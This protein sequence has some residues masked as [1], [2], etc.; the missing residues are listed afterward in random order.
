MLMPTHH[1]LIGIVGP[2]GAGKTTLAEGLGRAFP[3]TVYQEKP[4]ENPYFQEFYDDLHHQVKGSTAV[5]NSELFFLEAA[6]AQ[7]KAARE[8]LSSGIVIWD[9]PI[10]GHLM[11]A[12]LL[13]QQELLSEAQYQIYKKRYDECLRQILLPDLFLVA[14]VGS[15]QK[16]DVEILVE[17]IAQRGRP[18]ELETPLAYW[19]K[20]VA[21]WQAQT[22]HT[23]AV[24]HLLVNTA[25][26]DW[27]TEAGVQ[28]VKTAVEA[29]FASQLTS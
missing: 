11:Y 2:T 10:Q 28:Q 23:Q 4:Q 19:Q 18:E 17:H 13:R 20:Q 3:A 12:E 22:A 7:A 26:I 25:E 14:T 6:F 9:V 8:K 1:K 27:R 15:A 5:F 29:V 21:Y 24:P 16:K